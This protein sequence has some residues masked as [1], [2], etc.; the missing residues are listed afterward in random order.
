MFCGRYELVMLLLT[1][2]ETSPF[3]RDYVQLKNI[4]D[5]LHIDLKR[6]QSACSHRFVCLPVETNR[7]LVQLHQSLPIQREASKNFF[8]VLLSQAVEDQSGFIRS[9]IVQT[10][11]EDF[12][13]PAF[14]DVIAY[15]NR[16]YPRINTARRKENS[17]R[18]TPIQR[19]NSIVDIHQIFSLFDPDLRPKMVPPKPPPPK[20][21]PTL[22]PVNKQPITFKRLG[23]RIST[24]AA[25]SRVNNFEKKRC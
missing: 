10:I 20:P 16:R 17:T 15:L 5:Y 21:L 13:S 23:A 25:F 1:K 6:Q 22:P 7:I 4:I 9:L 19:E 8:E 24:I 11:G 18:T 3:V 2:T 14:T 12:S